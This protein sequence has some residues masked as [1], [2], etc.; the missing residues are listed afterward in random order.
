MR[1][2]DLNMG[3]MVEDGVTPRDDDASQCHDGS[4]PCGDPPRSL[5]SRNISSPVVN[6]NAL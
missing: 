3:K 4:N 6:S 2:V 1:I 5:S